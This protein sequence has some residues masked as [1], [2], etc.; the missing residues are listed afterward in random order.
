MTQQHP[1]LPKEIAFKEE[2][3]AESMAR[4]SGFGKDLFFELESHFPGMIS[5]I[6][7]FQPQDSQKEDIWAFYDDGFL[8]FA[9]QLEPYGEVI[10]LWDSN[11][12]N[13]IEIVTWWEN[14]YEAAIAFIEE[15]FFGKEP[16]GKFSFE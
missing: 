3:L 13:S 12:E 4:Y 5:K 9:I 10:V 14:E 16:T 7:F 8:L 11:P 2:T 6:R 1:L 15:V